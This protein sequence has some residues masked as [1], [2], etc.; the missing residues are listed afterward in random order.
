MLRCAVSSSLEDLQRLHEATGWTPSAEQIRPRP[1]V[2]AQKELM[3]TNLE[4]MWVTLA[5][6]VCY[7]VFGM[8]TT[9][10]ADGRRAAMRPAPTEPMRLVLQPY[11][12]DLPAGTEHMVLWCPAPELHWSE[13]AITAAIARGVDARWGGGEFVW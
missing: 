13:T 7:K 12:Y 4:Q 9:R 3:L 6:V 5:D 10:A 2:R 11:P 1:T 8:A